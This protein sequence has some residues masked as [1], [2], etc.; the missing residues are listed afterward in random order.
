LYLHEHEH[1]HCG[2]NKEDV[3]KDTSYYNPHLHWEAE[4]PRKGLGSLLKR[5][6]HIGLVC[7][8]I[9]KSLYFYEE[10]LGFQQIRRPNFD[11][12]GAWLTMGNIE[13]H[14]IKGE[15]TALPPDNDNLIVGHISLETD[16]PEEVF[17]GLSEYGVEFKKNISVPD[18]LGLTPITQYFLRDPDGY[19][20]E[21]C[22]C[23]PLTDFCLGKDDAGIKYDEAVEHVAPAQIFMLSF[24]GEV[25]ENTPI[26][27]DMPLP[28]EEWAAQADPVKLQNMLSRC[29]IYGDLMQGETEESISLALRQANNSV[30]SATRILRRK[31]VES[32]SA[33]YVPPTVFIS[34]TEKYQPKALAARTLTQS[35]QATKKVSPYVEMAKHLFEKADVNHDGTIAKEELFALMSH[36][37]HGL[38]RESFEE[39]YETIDTDHSGNLSFEEFC[40]AIA[41]QPPQ[42]SSEWNTLFRILD[43][44]GNGKVTLPEMASTLG[45]F[46]YHFDDATMEDFFIEN[47]LDGSGSLESDELK[48]IAMKVLEA[49]K[50][51]SL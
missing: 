47:D 9:A 33:F 14:L 20:L 45:S 13:L 41:K 18:G 37:Q 25:M 4:K 31:K 22:V 27:S 12:Y 1:L 50:S 30:P 46:G 2:L 5:V 51:V 40:H 48:A 10:I 11:R 28:E 23:Q 44:D 3:R 15:P 19:Y 34:G 35:T 49:S 21:L 38:P 24:L 17:V 7:S 32:G 39:W 26:S 42:D 8:D 43:M 29:R 16:Y 36:L 6:N